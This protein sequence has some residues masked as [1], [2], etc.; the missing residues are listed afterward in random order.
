MKIR[1][2]IVADGQIEAFSYRGNFLTVSVK[3]DE[4]SIDVIFHDVL[5]MKALSPDGQDL[6]HLAENCASS[7]LYEVCVAAEEPVDG[8]K[9]FS[10]IS[11]WTNEPL[12]IVVANDVQAYKTTRQQGELT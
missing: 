2:I 5:G 9:E 8:F 12:I 10:F 6:S 1:E 7:F 11:A 4:G 3:T